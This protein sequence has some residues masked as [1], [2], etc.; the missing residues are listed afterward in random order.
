MHSSVAIAIR[1]FNSDGALPYGHFTV[2]SSS[3][4]PNTDCDILG[5]AREV[6]SYS[7]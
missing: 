7:V 6:I 3:L 5:T 2:V 4:Y 1:L